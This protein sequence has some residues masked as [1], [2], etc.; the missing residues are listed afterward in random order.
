MKYIMLKKEQG[1]ITRFVPIIFPNELVHSYVANALL[2]SE[3]LEGFQVHSA[4][5]L[6]S[7]DVG[8]NISGDSITLG[9]SSNPDDARRITMADYGGCLE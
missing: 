8:G 5:E 3:Q 2:S 6:S 1:L 9:I 7:I 4:G